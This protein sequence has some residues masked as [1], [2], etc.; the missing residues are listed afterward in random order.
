MKYISFIND[1]EIESACFQLLGASTKRE[2][3]SK[4]GFFGSGLKYAV[5]FLVRNDIPFRFYS[6]LKE[7]EVTT[8]EVILRNQSFK[9]ILI[10]NETTSITTEWGIN[11][12]HWQVYRELC[13]NV[14]DED[15]TID[16]TSSPEGI[17][18]KTCLYVQ[19]SAFKKYYTHPENYF[20]PELVTK[21]EEVLVKNK[22]SKLIV[23]K[24]GM[25]VVEDN[26]ECESQDK[27]LFDYQLSVPLSEER[28]ANKSYIDS[29][30][31]DYLMHSATDE[32]CHK[33][34]SVLLDTGKI[35]YEHK[36]LHY[37]GVSSWR[38]AHA[39]GWKEALEASGATIFPETE[40]DRMTQT[41]GIQ[42][43]KTRKYKFI[44]GQIYNLFLRSFPTG[45]CF[46]QENPNVYELVENTNISLVKKLDGLAFIARSFI[47]S[48][49]YPV[50]IVKF[51][52]A[53]TMGL[54]DR[55]NG[56]ICISY[57]I[58]NNSD[59]YI[60]STIVE[61]YIH[62]YEQAEDATR[63]FQDASCNLIAKLLMQLTTSG[64]KNENYNDT[65]VQ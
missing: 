36:M 2:D 40:E 5:A 16:D 38:R 22:P 6:G 60:L 43:C 13:A 42:G 61:E 57:N 37:A 49:D 33:V 65:Q 19:H 54:A 4:I 44:N 26:D 3:D 47:P 41:Y 35:H 21:G 34:I 56:I 20:R 48:F 1:G 58:F 11:W 18:G 14:Y 31:V 9:Q 8:K 25:R 27:S 46:I 7:I 59:E 64:S 10:D 63:K 15:G 32:L 23:F 53:Q 39:N 45:S 29:H 17:E 28:L 55:E 50:K 62:L 12:F 51:R 52:D 24:K 30:L